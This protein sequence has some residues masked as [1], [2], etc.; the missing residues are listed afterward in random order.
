VFV[1]LEK[2]PRPLQ[3]SLCASFELTPAEARLAVGIGSGKNLE[4]IADELG[5]LKETA[6]SQLKSIFLKAGVRRQAE[7][8][9][10]LGSFLNSKDA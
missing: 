7:L 4:S 2:R 8:V 6:R 9:A 3:E 5:I 10:L 1:D